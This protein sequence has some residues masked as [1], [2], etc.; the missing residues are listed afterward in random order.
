[1]NN[2]RKRKKKR[3]G[4]WKSLLTFR[5]ACFSLPFYMRLQG[6]KEGIDAEVVEVVFTNSSLN[7]FVVKERGEK[8]GRVQL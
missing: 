8:M 6:N 1:M 5:R 2:K 3:V 7:S 4:D